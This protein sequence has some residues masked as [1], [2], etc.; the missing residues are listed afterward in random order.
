M[1]R[2]ILFAGLGLFAI[3]AVSACGGGGASQPA[4]SIKVN[5]TEFKFDPSTISA[6]TGKVT[7]FLVNSGTVAHDMVVMGPGGD[8][9]AASELVQPGNSSVFTVSNLT[10]GSYPFICDQPGHEASGMKGTLTVT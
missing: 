8:R 3:V 7:F 9:I 10:A 2:A 6:P 4:G 5:M 1:R